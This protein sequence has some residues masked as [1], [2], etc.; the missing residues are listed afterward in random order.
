MH[1]K[2]KNQDKTTELMQRFTEL[3]QKLIDVLNMPSVDID[4]KVTKATLKK[5]L[6]KYIKHVEEAKVLLEEYE[7][8]AKEIEKLTSKKADGETLSKAVVD[9]REEEKI[10][11]FADAYATEIVVV[12]EKVTANKRKKKTKTSTKEL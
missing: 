2:E 1:M 12:D 11:E 5:N 8:V 7:S 4:E 10:E 3:E 6:S 9:L